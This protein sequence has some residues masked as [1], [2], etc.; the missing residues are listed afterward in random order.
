MVMM[1]RRRRMKMMMMQVM[2]MMMMMKF[3]SKGTRSGAK[4]C[5]Q[6]MQCRASRQWSW[7]IFDHQICIF[8]MEGWQRIM[9]TRR[10]WS[11]LNDDRISEIASN[12]Y[13]VMRK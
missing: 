4:L 13:Q 7:K 1:M 6:E 10:E 3:M 2:M 8:A 9:A 12:S 11:E 5:R